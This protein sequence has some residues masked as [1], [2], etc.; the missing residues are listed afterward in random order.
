M[1]VGRGRFQKNQTELQEIMMLKSYEAI[2]EQGQ[3]K[4]IH[5]TPVI[6]NARVIITILE[7]I[8]TE[9]KKRQPPP[10]LKGSVIWK[11]DPFAPEMS[12][13]EWETALDRTARQI[14]GDPEAFK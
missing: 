6:K 13:D 1:A 7:E 10:E 11:S 8:P 9:R 12:D 4:W 2:Y 5:E 14:A 3:F